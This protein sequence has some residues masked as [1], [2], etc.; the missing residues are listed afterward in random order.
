MACGIPVAAS[1]NPGNEWWIIEG[2][3]GREFA[4]GDVATLAQLLAVD[5]DVLPQTAAALALVRRQ[6]DWSKNRLQLT[7]VM[8]FEPRD[9][10]S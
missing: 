1:A 8:A 5:S 4:I 3:T 7:D 9:R 2:E 6:G 10:S